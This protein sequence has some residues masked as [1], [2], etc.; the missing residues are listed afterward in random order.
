MSCTHPP[1]NLLIYGILFSKS[2]ARDTLMK[3]FLNKCLQM[4]VPENKEIETQRRL[5]NLRSKL[6]CGPNTLPQVCLA[7]K[8]ILSSVY[9]PL[10]LPLLH[11]IISKLKPHFSISISLSPCLAFPELART[12][13]MKSMRNLKH[14]FIVVYLAN[15]NKALCNTLEID[16]HTQLISFPTFL[17]AKMSFLLCE[18]LPFP[19]I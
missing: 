13:I 11:G 4:I 12:K 14:L 1:L 2:P 7:P 8:T 19:F 15:F 3:I 9:P 5:S 10:L 18:D 16:N 17:E 6:V